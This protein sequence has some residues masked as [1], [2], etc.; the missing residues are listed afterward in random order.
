LRELGYTVLHANSAAAALRV[1]DSRQDIALLF[2]DIVMP[3]VD[4]RQLADEAQSR[5]LGLKILYT[6]GYTRNAVIHNGVLDPDVHLVTKPF[7]LEQLALKV[8]YA[9]DT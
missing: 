7:T 2:T 5:Q 8:R 3:E 6:T 1:L 4:G 9:L